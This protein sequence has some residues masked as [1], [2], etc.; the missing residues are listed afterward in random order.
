MIDK[1]LLLTEAEKIGVHLSDEA[2]NRFDLYAQELV[3]TNK[4]MN[5]TA[6]TDPTDIVYKHFI[7]SLSILP[8]LPEGPVSLIDVG[9]GAG[10]PGIPLLIARPE[11]KL[12]LLDSLNKRLDFL[13]TVCEKLQLKAT[14]VHARAEE[15]GQNPSMREQFDVATARA[16]AN[17]PVLCEWC[18]P[19]VKVGGQFIAMK[20][21]SG[22]EELSK[23]CN[24]IKVLG[25]KTEKESS[26]LLNTSGESEERF[27]F[28]IKKL[29][30]T[31]MQ[32]PR[33]N[34]KIKKQPL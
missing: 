19:L 29:Q 1:Q 17:L 26:F 30:P 6:I 21:S 5:L 3:E 7:D 11:I 22:K 24:A 9:T 34:G 27:I 12:T 31:N 4:V 8:L 32:Y 20:G 2:L 23:A 33:P 15:A 25:A 14:T 10:F 13:K 16:V 18:I 28:S